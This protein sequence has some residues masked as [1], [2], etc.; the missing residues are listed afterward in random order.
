MRCGVIGAVS[1]EVTLLF[2]ELK[3]SGSPVKASLRGNLEF[4]EGTLRGCP[5]V[6]V[7][8]GVGKVNA[9][10]CAQ[11][12][13]SDFAVDAIVNTGSAGGLAEG[14]AV[15]D[16]VVATDAVQH[17]FD[18]TAFGY[19]PGQIPGTDS[20]FWPADPGL[21]AAAL[22]AFERSGKAPERRMVPGRV[23]SGD[24]FVTEASMRERIARD[25]APACVE[26]EGAAV[27]QVAAVNRV[28]FA[29]LRSI[30]DLAGH[31]A[32]MSYED[33][34][35]QAAHTSAGVVMEMLGI[36]AST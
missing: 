19:P 30:S 17:D 1:D 16:M 23:A 11:I 32:T 29:I 9:A 28:P 21:R 26:M 13:I 24:A 33:F 12:L 31:E 6:V 20:P 22:K 3:A 34:A 14:L 25:F 15:L 5:A 36:L 18:V 8:C 2:E 35:V 4:H 10:L 27:A 7:C